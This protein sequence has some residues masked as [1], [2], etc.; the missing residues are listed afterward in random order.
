[1]YMAGLPVTTQS[2]QPLEQSQ[3]LLKLH[4]LKQ[5]Q[6]KREQFLQQLREMYSLQPLRIVMEIQFQV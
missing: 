6:V 5:E 2:L 3:Q 1:M 4:L